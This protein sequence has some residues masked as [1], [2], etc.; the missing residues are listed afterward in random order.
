MG[1]SHSPRHGSM[2]FWPRKR[3][4]SEVARV[5]FWGNIKE[6]K[7][8]GLA[9]YKVGMAHAMVDDTR[10]TSISKGKTISWPV[11]IVECSP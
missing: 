5:R 7:L 3:A 11:T 9:G 10:E 1:K 8:M 4:K 2:Q 6:P